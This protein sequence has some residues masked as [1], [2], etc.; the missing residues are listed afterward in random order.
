MSLT[1]NAK[2]QATDSPSKTSNSTHDPGSTGFFCLHYKAR[3]R[4]AQSTLQ[5][6]FV[7][8]PVLLLCF[9]IQEVQN[10]NNDKCI[11]DSRSNRLSVWN[12]SWPVKL[13]KEHNLKQNQTTPIFYEIHAMIQVL[14][15]LLANGVQIAEFLRSWLDSAFSSRPQDDWKGRSLIQENNVRLYLMLFPPFTL[16]AMVRKAV[17]RLWTKPVQLGAVKK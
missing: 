14:R 3:P 11:F 10:N 17:P 5:L 1:F 4:L 2:R 7:F 6:C 15:V 12:L 9:Y 8:V 16:P 13:E